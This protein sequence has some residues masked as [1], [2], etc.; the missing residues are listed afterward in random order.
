MKFIN[1]LIASQN[2]IKFTLVI[3]LVVLI[4]LIFDFHL[5]IYRKPKESKN[6]NIQFKYDKKLGKIIV[7]NSINSEEYITTFLTKEDFATLKSNVEDLDRTLKGK[8]HPIT[9]DVLKRQDPVKIDD[10][11]T[12]EIPLKLLKQYQK[13]QTVLDHYRNKQRQDK[14]VKKDQVK[15]Q[16][17]K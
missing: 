4:F 11:Q 15:N 3:I 1:S 2:Q 10:N 6:A 12:V 13:N 9:I 16:A 14:I 7:L 5:H 8:A 17:E